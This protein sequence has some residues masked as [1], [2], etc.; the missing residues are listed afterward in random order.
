MA[1]LIFFV[2]QTIDIDNYVDDTVEKKVISFKLVIPGHS[3][4]SKLSS[5]TATGKY[6]SVPIE[7]SVAK[8]LPLF[9]AVFPW[10]IQIYS[11]W[12][13][14]TSGA[15]LDLNVTEWDVE[16]S[17]ETEVTRALE[18]EFITE[19]GNCKDAFSTEAAYIHNGNRS[20]THAVAGSI[21]LPIAVSRDILRS[22]RTLKINSDVLTDTDAIIPNRIRITEYD[23]KK[24]V[25][26]VKYFLSYRSHIQLSHETGST[27]QLGIEYSCQNA[28]DEN[29][30]DC[31][32]IITNKLQD[33]SSSPSKAECKIS[34][35]H[36]TRPEAIQESLAQLLSPLGLVAKALDNMAVVKLKVSNL[37]HMLTIVNK[38]ST[39]EFLKKTLV[40]LL[41]IGS[42]SKVDNVFNQAWHSMSKEQMLFKYPVNWRDITNYLAIPKYEDETLDLI[43]RTDTEQWLQ[44]IIDLLATQNNGILVLWKTLQDHF[45]PDTKD[46]QAKRQKITLLLSN[47]AGLIREFEKAFQNDPQ[48]LAAQL[49]ARW[50]WGVWELRLK[51]NFDPK[52]LNL[53]EIKLLI[54]YSLDKS[55]LTRLK[56]RCYTRA[57]GDVLTSV[58]HLAQ[59]INVEQDVKS[60][61]KNL[62]NILLSQLKLAEQLPP[63][64]KNK[65]IFNKLLSKRIAKSLAQGVQ[66]YIQLYGELAVEGLVI[67]PNLSILIKPTN[68]SAIKDIRGYAIALAVGVDQTIHTSTWLTDKA[69]YI[70]EVN[71][72]VNVRGKP[73]I[74]SDENILHCHG[75]FGGKISH[76]REELHYDYPEHLGN[77]TTDS[78]DADLRAIDLARPKS[79]DDEWRLPLI[80]YGL[81]YTAVASEIAM[82]GLI[83]DRRFATIDPY[84][85]KNANDVLKGS[86]QQHTGYTYLSRVKLG[87]PKISIKQESENGELINPESREGQNSRL[88]SAAEQ[89]KVAASILQSGTKKN[90]AP[91][92]LIKPNKQAYWREEVPTKISITIETPTLT[93][94]HVIERWINADIV[95]NEL[96]I[97]DGLDVLMTQKQTKDLKY[98][99]NSLRLQNKNNQ[100]SGKENRTFNHP[101]I[102]HIGLRLINSN[103]IEIAKIYIDLKNSNWEKEWRFCN[104]FSIEI[105]ELPNAQENNEA[106]LRSRKVYVAAGS[107]IKIETFALVEKKWMDGDIRRLHKTYADEKNFPGFFASEPTEFW[108]ECL[109]KFDVN[110]FK[111]AAKSLLDAINVPHEKLDANLLLS[112]Q[113]TQQIDATWFSGVKLDRGLYRW[114][115]IPCTLG[116]F[117]ERGAPKSDMDAWLPNYIGTE[118]AKQVRES[119]KPPPAVSFKTTI[120]NNTWTIGEKTAQSMV[121]ATWDAKQNHNAQHGYYELMLVPRFEALIDENEKARLLTLAQAQP[122]KAI[123]SFLIADRFPRQLAEY[124][125]QCPKP[126]VSTVETEAYGLTSDNSGVRRVAN[127]AVL[128]SS[129]QFNDTASNSTLGG[130]AERIECSLVITRIEGVAELGPDPIFHKAPVWIVAEA[131]KGHLQVPH[132]TRDTSVPMNWGIDV[133]RFAGLTNDIGTNGNVIASQ[134][135]VRPSG[136][137][138]QRYW[139]MAKVQIRRW[140]EPTLVG[141]SSLQPIKNGDDK[142]ILNQWMLQ[143]RKSGIEL[144]PKDFCLTLPQNHNCET[145]SIEVKKTASTEIVAK[146]ELKT[147]SKNPVRFLA[148]WHKGEWGETATALWSLQMVRQ[149]LLNLDSSDNYEWVTNYTYDP[150]MLQSGTNLINACIDSSELMLILKSEK[151]L[152][153][154]FTCFVNDLIVSDYGAPQWL[155]FI[156]S[157]VREDQLSAF[158]YGGVF[159]K[160]KQLFKLY[161]TNIRPIAKGGADYKFSTEPI[162]RDLLI[163]P[164]QSKFS[165]E[166]YELILKL[167][168]SEQL[169][170]ERTVFDLLLVFKKELDAVAISDSTS[171]ATLHS[172][173]FP[174]LQSENED[175]HMCFKWAFGKNIKDDPKDHEYIAM[176]YNFQAP[177]GFEA[178]DTFE[179]LLCS[180]FVEEEHALRKTP[181]IRMMPKYQLFKVLNNL[182]INLEESKKMDEETLISKLVP[183]NKK[184]SISKTIKL[185]LPHDGHKHEAIIDLFDDFGW[186]I[187]IWPKELKQLKPTSLSGSS[188]KIEGATDKPGGLALRVAGGKEWCRLLTSTTSETINGGLAMVGSVECEYLLS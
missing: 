174:H 155:T 55:T 184:P 105:T 108:V 163:H 154:N 110:D 13:L 79:E 30:N 101:A 171:I 6:S 40:V 27:T 76:G 153:K 94:W 173:W 143:R 64:L 149:E 34:T 75:T 99:C 187:R 121:L 132:I 118:A 84:I 147:E 172:C 11:W 38:E 124:R 161:R 62:T 68:S 89:S 35:P 21:D 188:V 59:S 83:L 3:E 151:S 119:D 71:E 122:Q 104:K 47:T 140:L 23:S 146:I 179:G 49:Y 183:T 145:L 135:V 19:L 148:S 107:Y 131:G 81:T 41:G 91:I 18:I 85:L 15:L 158:E 93:D 97:K 139:T 69:V 182:N 114:T 180:M 185:T 48:N 159:D 109:P 133:S 113:Q 130:I 141:G 65:L 120:T 125:L 103:K 46:E 8:S 98:A 1:S 31:F 111:T 181:S 117:D 53:D 167:D 142:I 86:Q 157:Y 152:D 116:L 164:V 138:V 28:A 90:K 50:L 39:L 66:N 20:L 60:P 128:T 45:K 129:E 162:V 178:F 168:E 160:N 57:D 44:N 156:G 58:A 63:P 9:K 175:M 33:V 72:K 88:T 87:Q 136:A 78:I 2:D 70:T 61:L 17:G 170:T 25:E 7:A 77:D 67:E 186:Y 51:S 127:G 26:V 169:S 29:I 137:D 37:D 134:L 4:I 144:I 22:I 36:S 165:K 115:G 92:F 176:M 95:R 80:G 24:R 12:K 5:G 56:L 16:V 112:L 150:F 32:W 123:K 73:L 14:N 106:S 96:G 54:D 100:E 177:E 82:S 42:V 74:N 126:F 10:N 52:K 102:R 43:L 166:N